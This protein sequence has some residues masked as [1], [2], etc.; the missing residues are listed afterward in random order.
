MKNEKDNTGENVFCFFK[1]NGE[2]INEK[3][4]NAFKEY[5]KEDINSNEKVD[6]FMNKS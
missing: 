5:I 2:N 4:G 6:N 3:L 1:D